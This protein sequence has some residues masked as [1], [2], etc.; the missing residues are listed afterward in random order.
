M[1]T[2]SKTTVTKE[3]QSLPHI[4]GYSRTVKSMHEITHNH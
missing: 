2:T 1:M 3:L 4:A